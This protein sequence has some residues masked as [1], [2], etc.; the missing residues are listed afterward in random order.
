MY[1]YDGQSPSQKVSEHSIQTVEDTVMNEIIAKQPC[2]KCSEVLRFETPTPKPMRRPF[3][4][5]MQQFPKRRH[6]EHRN[7]ERRE[8]DTKTTNIN[9]DSSCQSNSQAGAQEVQLCVVRWPEEPRWIQVKHKRC[10]ALEQVAIAKTGSTAHYDSTLNSNICEDTTSEINMQNIA[11]H[12][13]HSC[14]LHDAPTGLLKSAAL[15]RTSIAEAEFPLLVGH[16]F[17]GIDL[18]RHGLQTVLKRPLH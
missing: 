13:S 9:V 8:N 10:Q 16:D 3:W 17:A 15:H 11:D 5:T 4:N 2:D 18:W 14:A 6:V 1:A 7:D 12:S